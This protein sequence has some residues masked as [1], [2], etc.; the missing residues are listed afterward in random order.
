VLYFCLSRTRARA[1]TN[2]GSHLAHGEFLNDL[3]LVLGQLVGQGLEALVM[4]G[5]CL[6]PIQSNVEVASAVVQLHHLLH[7]H[8]NVHVH[9]HVHVHVRR[10]FIHGHGDVRVPFLSMS[11]TLPWHT[12]SVE[13]HDKTR[14]QQLLGRYLSARAL[15]VVKQ[16]ADTLHEGL[17]KQRR[18]RVAGLGAK[19][20]EGARHS[21]V[22]AIHMVSETLRHSDAK[23]LRVLGD[24][25]PKIR[26]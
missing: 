24:G 20:L 9:V 26:D 23:S 21:K 12:L 3:L 7:V 18:A 19:V 22:P 8:I 16:F 17:A 5:K 25:P 14:P 11:S 13:E 6:C 4:A 1:C 2:V 15:P 10:L